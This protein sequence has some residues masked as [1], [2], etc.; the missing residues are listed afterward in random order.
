MERVATSSHQAQLVQYML[1]AEARTAAAQVQAATGLV[2]TD[3]KGI[4]GDSGRLVDLESHYRR[5]ERYVDEGEVVSGRIDTMHDAVGG[6]IDLTNRVNALVTSLQGVA[7][8]S[9]GAAEGIKAEAA[10]L[11]EEFAALLNTQ[12]E[13]RYLFAGA[14]T[15]RAPVDLDGGSWTAPTSPSSPDTGYYSGDGSVAYFQAS[16]DLILEY[17]VTADNPAIE[18]ALRAIGL[19]ANMATDPVDTALVNEAD[20]LADEAADGLTVVQT[21]LGAASA[22]LERTIDRHLDEQLVLQTQ[23]DDIK[24]IDLA[25][26]TA[27]LSQLQASLEATMSLLKILEETS[28]SQYL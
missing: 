24:S 27:R 16:D 22:T 19:I 25:E 8:Q 12:Q 3:Y 9:D 7:G 6:M 11:L 28:L 1:K 4:A 10:A 21:G 2:S 20:E 26:A 13:G 18:K 23:V 15:D 5:S 17:G 14:R